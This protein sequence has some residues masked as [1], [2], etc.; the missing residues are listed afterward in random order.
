MPCKKQF[1]R[2]Q[3]FSSQEYR[4]RAKTIKALAAAPQ[5]SQIARSIQVCGKRLNGPDKHP[6]RCNHALC[7]DCRKHYAKGPVKLALARFEPHPKDAIHSATVIFDARPT[8]FSDAAW[9]ACPLKTKLDS[10]K[11]KL[12][13]TFERS[14]LTGYVII[15]AIEFGWCTWPQ[16]DTN[17]GKC[18][19]A[20][21]EENG[22]A[23]EPGVTGILM[24][25]CHFLICAKD[26]DDYA[27]IDKI[28]KILRRAY[29]LPSQVKVRPLDDSQDKR[30]AVTKC[31]SYAVKGHI[32]KTPDA[33]I[34]EVAYAMAHI[35]RRSFAFRWTGGVL[36]KQADNASPRPSIDIVLPWAIFH[37]PSTTV[38]Q[39]ETKAAK[40]LRH[41]FN[42]LPFQVNAIDAAIN[43]QIQNH[44]ELTHE[45]PN[46][47]TRPGRDP[48]PP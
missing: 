17:K 47:E 1:Y 23:I 11:D 19:T 44:T 7:P 48:L 34:R 35:N 39:P 36:V 13:H 33:Q 6:Y 45:Q 18:G 26:G 4:Y 21:L 9:N 8:L 24:P 29:R 22:T 2:R 16:G 32:G 3:Q 20:C 14:S 27:S 15:G 41:G 43:S 12:M 30:T 28:R 10:H 25:H 5:T 46:P 42:L 31:A 38:K 40:Q 37:P